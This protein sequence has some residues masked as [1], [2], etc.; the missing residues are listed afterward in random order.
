MKFSQMMMNT[1]LVQVWDIP[2]PE[3]DILLYHPDCHSPSHVLITAIII[4][5]ILIISIIIII[6]IKACLNGSTS[7]VG[8][9]SLHCKSIDHR[10]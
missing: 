9:S 2:K 7:H 1:P 5:I 6:H 3:A 8:Y 4:T 10:L